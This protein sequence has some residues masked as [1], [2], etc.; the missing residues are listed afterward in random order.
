MWNSIWSESVHFVKSIKKDQYPFIY[1]VDGSSKGYYS[2]QLLLLTPQFPIDGAKN[3]S[4]TSTIYVSGF[5]RI[6]EPFLRSGQ[7]SRHD[8][9]YEVVKDGE[10]QLVPASDLLLFKRLYGTSVLQYAPI[11]EKP[12]NI[13]LVI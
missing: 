2:F 9:K 1:Y 8:V 6:S 4:T 13:S 12:E 5:R 11:F 7:I 3:S 10:T